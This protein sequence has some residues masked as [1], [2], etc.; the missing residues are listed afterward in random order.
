MIKENAARVS[1]RR[2]R[3]GRRERK[4]RIGRKAG[5]SARRRFPCRETRPFISS[6]SFLFSFPREPTFPPGADPVAEKSPSVYCYLQCLLY[7]R[8]YITVLTS[9]ASDLKFR[10]L[11][12]NVFEGRDTK[13]AVTTQLRE[14]VGLG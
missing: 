4:E 7:T 1:T 8:R 5:P 9:R 12:A 2:E 10:A 6:R 14:C 11:S 13:A 3:G